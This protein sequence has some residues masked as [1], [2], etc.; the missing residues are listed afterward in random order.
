MLS[1]CCRRNIILHCFDDD[2]SEAGIRERAAAEGGLEN[3]LE[4][5][6]SFSTSTTRCSPE[7]GGP[8]LSFSAL[9]FDDRSALL[10]EILASH[11][12][13]PLSAEELDKLRVVPLFT[14]AAGGITGS[15][16]GEAVALCDVSSAFWCPSESALEGVLTGFFF[17][18]TFVVL[19]QIRVFCF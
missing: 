18:A 11:D 10:R 8:L 4:T 6:T 14:T 5:A 19:L 17:F 16:G 13:Q 7:L 1:L 9:T 12:E 15:G 3:H 2:G